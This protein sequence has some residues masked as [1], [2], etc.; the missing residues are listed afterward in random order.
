MR[1]DQPGHKVIPAPPVRRVFRAKR[2]QLERRARWAPLVRLEH[3]VQLAQLAPPVQ[4][5]R[6]VTQAPLVRLVQPGRKAS[7][8]LRVPPGPLAPRE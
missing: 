5:D 1:L 6:R 7:P 8:E 2:E 3:V 4:Q